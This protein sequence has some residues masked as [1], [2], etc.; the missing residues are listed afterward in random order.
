MLK[1]FRNGK[2]QAER[3]G[4][5][6]KT[7]L[8]FSA[9]D[10]M[11]AIYLCVMTIYFGIAEDSPLW[12]FIYFLTTNTMALALVLR[13]RRFEKRSTYVILIV[14]Y[15]LTLL[16]NFLFYL[17]GVKCISQIAGLYFLAG[18]LLLIFGKKK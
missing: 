17:F 10:L 18:L 16:Y 2:G 13:L 15:S 5:T 7:A 8:R 12:D 1:F 9:I 3:Q 11:V 6:Q 4:T 14:I